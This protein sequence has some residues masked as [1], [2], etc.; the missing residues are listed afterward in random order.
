MLKII[1]ILGFWSSLPITSNAQTIN[2]KNNTDIIHQKDTT[3]T[4]HVGDV[5]VIHT[6]GWYV[7]EYYIK[8]RNKA[9]LLR[10]KVGSNKTFD[11][12][13]YTWETGRKVAV[14]LY[15]TETDDAF[16]LKLF[17]DGN[18]SGMQIEDSQIEKLNAK[19][20]GKT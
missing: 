14:R 8:L 7:I 13:G 15:N 18:T 17:G 4:H 2:Y 5:Q 9:T 11:K 16:E 20:G 19:P 10:G 12:A 3:I 6:D 1:L